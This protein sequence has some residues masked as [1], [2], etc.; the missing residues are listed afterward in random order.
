MLIQFILNGQEQSA[1]ADP[2]LMLVDLL[3]SKFLLSGVKVSCDQAV[4]G[5]CTVL[6]DDR[7]VSSCSTFAFEIDGHRVETIEGLARDGKLS[8]VQQA[9][10]A[11]T[12][13]QCGFCTPGFIMTVTAMLRA[14]PKPDAATVRRWLSSNVCRCTGYKMILEA[15]EMAAQI[16][17]A[18]SARS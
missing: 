16:Q 10:V 12:A 7:P 13:F 15:V 18:G 1:E 9:F 2:N 14:N 5:A 3:R 4:C 6:V 17:P 8:P 11:K